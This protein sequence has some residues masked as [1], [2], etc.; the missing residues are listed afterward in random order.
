MAT[1]RFS[2]TLKLLQVSEFYAPQHELG[3]R[4][5]DPALAIPWRLPVTEVSNKDAGWPLL[6]AGPRVHSR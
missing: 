2:T 1:K 4:Y 5:D 6:P 3:L